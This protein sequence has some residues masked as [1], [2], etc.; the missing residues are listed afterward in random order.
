MGQSIIYLKADI[1]WRMSNSCPRTPIEQATWTNRQ[2][3]RDTITST[4]P[5]FNRTGHVCMNPQTLP[6]PNHWASRLNGSV[7]T[8]RV[9]TGIV[10]RVM[11]G[12][13]LNYSTRATYA[14]AHGSGWNTAQSV[15]NMVTALASAF[16]GPAASLFDGKAKLLTNGQTI[17]NTTAFHS[18]IQ[19]QR[20]N[21]PTNRTPRAFLKAMFCT[22][23][24]PRVQRFGKQLQ[25]LKFR[26]RI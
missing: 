16:V 21:T 23:K 19:H 5:F 7:V 14:Q 24:V 13:T 18:A 11:A 4:T 10:L 9:G 20:A 15:T 8:R 25:L 1:K 3:V 22:P 6:C 2:P 12:D 17:V 26:S